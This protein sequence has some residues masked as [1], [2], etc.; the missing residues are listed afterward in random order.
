TGD[1]IT[2]TT[3]NG[4]P[5][6]IPS[7]AKLSFFVTV[8]SVALSFLK[9][10]TNT[11]ILSKPNLRSLDGE[12]V[13]FM[14]GDEVPILQTQFQS[15]GAGGY[16]NIPVASY[17]YKS[18]GVDIKLTPT[19]HKNNDVSIK[20][21]LKM[22]FIT[23]YVGAMPQLGK[24][25]LECIIRLKEGETSII[26]GF[27]KDEDRDIMKGIPL[28]SKIPVLG[29]LFGSTTK[30][31]VQTDLIFSITPRIIR[32]IDITEQDKGAIW[33]NTNQSVGATNASKPGN[34]PKGPGGPDERKPNA[35]K[36]GGKNSVIIAPR[37]RKIPVNSVSYFTIRLNAGQDIS[38]LAVGGSISGAKAEIQQL[39]VDYFGGKDDVK[40][41]KNS[42]GDSFDLGYSFTGKPIKNSILAQLKIK[43]LEK[44][45]YTISI[46]NASGM[47]KDG[48]SVD[49]TTNSAE[50]EVY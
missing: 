9:A 48:K 7:L 15:S 41:M 6:T 1:S 8:P 36:R 27:I 18:V 40:T 3:V 38:S 46:S 43:F 47:S 33:L 35:R 16:G 24:R 12:E 29:K 45:Q 39:K 42:S 19:I 23:G 34:T 11:K 31:S 30:G 4:G 5:F 2:T 28:L 37:K 14:V 17:N 21:K 49:L 22:D 20:I 13:K 32:K 26:G 50:V 25:E 44:G 10:D